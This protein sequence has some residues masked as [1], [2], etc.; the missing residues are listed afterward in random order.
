MGDRGSFLNIGAGRVIPSDLMDSDNYFLVNLDPNYEDERSTNI[1]EIEKEHDNWM[2]AKEKEVEDLFGSKTF[3][4]N[5][6]WKEFIPSYF[7][8]FDNIYISRYLEH[9][10]MVDV[11]F[12]IY[13]ISTIALECGVVEG[14]VPNYKILAE[15]I[16][17]ENP[18]DVGF[19]KEN[20]LT[21]TEVVNE[22]YDP[23]ASIWTPDRIKYFFE[24]EGRFKVS[25]IIPQMEFEDRNIYSW[26]SAIKI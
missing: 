13:M 1:I 8:S 15:R 2:Q 18:F 3:Y 25:K 9:V 26:F 21:T 10:P 22:P 16:L 4:C 11:P 20:I 5:Y 12:F 6:G 17:N 7:R 23:H 19:E 24:L 14:I